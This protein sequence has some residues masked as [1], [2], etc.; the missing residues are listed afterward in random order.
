MEP[1]EQIL[2]NELDDFTEVLF[3]NKGQVDVGFEINRRKHFVLR[4]KKAI[5]I[6]DHG[7][8]FN[9]KSSFIYKTHTQCEGFS[10]RKNFWL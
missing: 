1:K 6:G 7:C 3:F 4:Q 2:F 8:T 5:I 9:N 10:I